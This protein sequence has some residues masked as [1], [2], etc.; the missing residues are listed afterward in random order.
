MRGTLWKYKMANRFAE[1][2]H[3]FGCWRIPYAQIAVSSAQPWRRAFQIWDKSK[4]NCP[5]RVSKGWGMRAA[6]KL[7]DPNIVG[8]Y[9]FSC[10]GEVLHIA[11]LN[12]RP[13]QKYQMGQPRDLWKS[14]DEILLY[15]TKASPTP[16]A[17]LCQSAFLTSLQTFPVSF[18]PACPACGCFQVCQWK[19][20]WSLKIIQTIWWLDFSLCRGHQMTYVFAGSR[21][22]WA[23]LQ[24]NLASILSVVISRC[25]SNWVHSTA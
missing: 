14:K 22:L 7:L 17:D 2:Y 18:L 6:K 19:Y 10:V 23:T 20:S 25:L 24:K 11:I 12:F 9:S 16:S 5:A 15:S 3:H 21:V 13:I 8:S 4:V 1:N